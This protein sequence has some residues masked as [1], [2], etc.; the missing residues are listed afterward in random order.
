MNGDGFFRGSR[1]AA[2]ATAFGPVRI[3]PLRAGGTL[4]LQAE[5]GTDAGAAFDERAEKRWAEMC[6]ANPRLHDGPIWSVTSFNEATGVIG[7]RLDRYSRY[8]VRPSIGRGVR[9]LA[10]RGVVTAVD[11]GGVE[12]V[13]MGLRSPQTRVYGDMWEVLPGGGLPADAGAGDQPAQQPPRAEAFVAHL[14]Q[15][16]REEAGLE[17]AAAECRFAGV[18]DDSHAGGFDVLMRVRL[19][20]PLE[21]VRAE[22]GSR[23][24]E[25]AK[26]QWL[27]VGEVAAFDRDHGAE[28]SP[29]TRAIFRH[30]D[31]VRDGE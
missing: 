25:H 30:H 9:M 22:M 12:H 28:I 7:V 19:G 17:V 20:R 29:P 23:D 26:V 21:T 31:W 27:A 5:A 18:C 1:A 13:L 2:G 24:W 14:Q 10:V 4:V 15:E 6:A 3:W 16:A 8:A 11:A